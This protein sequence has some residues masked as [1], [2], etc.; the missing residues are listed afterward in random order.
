MEQVIL[1]IQKFSF[2]V[3]ENKYIPPK[4]FQLEMDSIILR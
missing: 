1:S 4:L 2:C 3:F